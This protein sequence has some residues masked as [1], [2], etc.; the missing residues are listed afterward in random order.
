MAVSINYYGVR[1]EDRK[2]ISSLVEGTSSPGVAAIDVAAVRQALLGGTQLT[3]KAKGTL[4]WKDDE[5]GYVFVDVAPT[6]ALVTQG[7][8]GG[9][10]VLDVMIDVISVLNAAGLNVYDPQRGSWFPGS[11]VKAKKPAPAVKAAKAAKAAKPAK[12]ASTR[13]AAPGQPKATP[14]AKK[15]PVL[16]PPAT[17][18]HVSKEPAP[19]KK[20]TKRP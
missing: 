12:P 15:Q 18:K 7:T 16:R 11:P 10:R 20:P 19:K 4:T 3:G 1:T 2:L 6:C 9:D 5:G 13:P 17:K 8:R 14:A